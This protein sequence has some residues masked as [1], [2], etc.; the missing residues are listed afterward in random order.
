MWKIGTAS[1]NKSNLSIISFT[2]FVKWKEP[3][4][5]MFVFLFAIKVPLNL[6]TK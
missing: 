4:P 1:A 3:V 5:L 6:N 2:S